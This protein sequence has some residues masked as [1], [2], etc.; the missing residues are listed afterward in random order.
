MRVRSGRKEKEG[1]V[2]TQD[3]IIVRG[4]IKAVCGEETQ[5]SQSNQTGGSLGK[6]WPKAWVAYTSRAK[7]KPESILQMPPGQEDQQI[8]NSQRGFPKD[9]IPE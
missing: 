7:P 3:D 1:L 4:G 6:G 5:N 9:R 2:P 8:T